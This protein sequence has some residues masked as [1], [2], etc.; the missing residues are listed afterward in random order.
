MDI[1]PPFGARSPP[2]S[3]CRAGEPDSPSMPVSPRSPEPRRTESDR[4]HV[5]DIHGK[6]RYGAGHLQIGRIEEANFHVVA[7]GIG[8]A[9]WAIGD[10]D[11]VEVQVFAGHAAD[12]LGGLE[13]VCR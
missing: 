12:D 4:D 13:R 9:D 5:T 7:I 3:D 1:P 10:G 2:A 11:G 8:P 6:A